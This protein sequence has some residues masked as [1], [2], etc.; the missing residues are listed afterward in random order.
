MASNRHVIMGTRHLMDDVQSE[1]LSHHHFLIN[2]LI[3]PVMQM[4]DH[5]ITVRANG[6]EHLGVGCLLTYGFQDEVYNVENLSTDRHLKMFSEFLAPA[7]FLDA[8]PW[9]ALADKIEFYRTIEDH[10]LVPRGLSKVDFCNIRAFTPEDGAN[11]EKPATILDNGQVGMY[12]ATY[13]QISPVGWAPWG[14]ALSV[15]SE[16]SKK[17]PKPLYKRN[18]H[19]M[20]LTSLITICKIGPIADD[21]M[22]TMGIQIRTECGESSNMTQDWMA[23]LITALCKGTGDWMIPLQIVMR[24]GFEL[25]SQNTLKRMSIIKRKVNNS[26]GSRVCPKLPADF[27][28]PCEQKWVHI[29]TEHCNWNN[30]FNAVDFFQP[31]WIRAL[32]SLENDD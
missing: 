31:L 15:Q 5:R 18:V 7:P 32:L 30:R 4:E 22:E 2:S 19:R 21:T 14:K 17:C 23:A 10:L 26:G 13:P 6:S 1:I 12:L 9:P 24:A 20:L 3:T 29:T 25:P 11:M 8:L 27:L 16:S 28:I